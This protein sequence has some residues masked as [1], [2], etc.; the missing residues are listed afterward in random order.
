MVVAMAR[1]PQGIWAVVYQRTTADICASH[2]CL[3]LSH[4]HMDHIWSTHTGGARNRQN[5][6]LVVG[7][8]DHS[9][10]L[11]H[12]FCHLA[13]RVARRPRVFLEGRQVRVATKCGPD[14]WNTLQYLAGNHSSGAV[15]ATN[16]FLGRRE[17]ATRLAY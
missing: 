11:A 5:A 13:S 14:N 7:N 2:R 17:D 12:L 9:H 10:T 1:C 4:L 15:V 8:S 6:A 3:A 16:S